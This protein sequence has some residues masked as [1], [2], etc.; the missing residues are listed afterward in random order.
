MVIQANFLYPNGFQFTISKMPKASFM[1]QR[2]S[3]PGVSLGMREIPTPFTRT[4]EPGQIAYD[5]LRISFLI[6]EDLSTYLELFHWMR[7]LGSPNNYTEYDGTKYD[8]RLI[9]LDSSKQSVL[10]VNFSDIFPVN[11]TP[12]ELDT[13]IIDLQPLV[14]DVSFSFDTMTFD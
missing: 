8:A 7:Q 1:V 6:T 2:V 9:V 10:S 14:A 5:Q 4:F 12:I 11:L 3:I 13:T